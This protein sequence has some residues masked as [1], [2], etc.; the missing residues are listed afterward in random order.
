MTDLPPKPYS[1]LVK[2]QKSQCLEPSGEDANRRMHDL[3]RGSLS[4]R[5]GLLAVEHGILVCA[6]LFRCVWT[7]QRL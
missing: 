2:L 1:D 5:C 7:G 4:E 6:F 3:H